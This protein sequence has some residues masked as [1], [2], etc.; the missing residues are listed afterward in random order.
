MPAFNKA[1]ME[2]LGIAPAAQ[3]LNQVPPKE[4][5]KAVPHTTVYHKDAVHQADLIYL[6][7]YYCFQVD[8]LAQRLLRQVAPKSRSTNFIPNS[9]CP[10]AREGELTRLLMFK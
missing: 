7:H 2:K 8:Q 3:T 6:P 1:M 4:K 10:R 9:D 5:G